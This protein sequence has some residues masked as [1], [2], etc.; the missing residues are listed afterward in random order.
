MM[1]Q[2]A[3]REMGSRGATIATARLSHSQFCLESSTDLPFRRVGPGI[4]R[5]LHT[6]LVVQAMA[7]VEPILI[8]RADRTRMYPVGI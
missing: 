1:F 2:R 8:T 4:E 7:P 5:Q 6:R 3:G